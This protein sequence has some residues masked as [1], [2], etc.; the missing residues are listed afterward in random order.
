MKRFPLSELKKMDPS[1]L[2]PSKLSKQLKKKSALLA[3][4]TSII[5]KDKEAIKNIF[6]PR[7]ALSQIP[8]YNPYGKYIVRL[9]INGS[10]KSVFVDDLIIIN[11]TGQ[12]STTSFH[13]E[14]DFY[15]SVTNKAFQ[16]LKHLGIKIDK[17][18]CVY[19]WML[20][21]PNWMPEKVLF[22]PVASKF[23]YFWDLISKATQSGTLIARRKPAKQNPYYK[24]VFY[25]VHI[26]FDVGNYRLLVMQNVSQ[27]DGQKVS[28]SLK[29]QP[30]DVGG[31]QQVYE[32]IFGQFKVI[33]SDIRQLK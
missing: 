21:G 11:S 8:V 26:A 15:F 23:F 25:N 7:T 9:Y 14:L 27:I 22:S 30:E 32:K 4:L 20:L 19:N 2:K 16:K 1:T 17:S 3:S 29:L 6:Y 13:N 31:N 33:R 12:N 5:Y 18:P 28:E 10:Y 24:R